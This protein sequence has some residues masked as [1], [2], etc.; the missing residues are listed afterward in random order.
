M[1][2]KILRLTDELSEYRK[3][4]LSNKEEIENYLKTLDYTNSKS[5]RIKNQYLECL[6]IVNIYYF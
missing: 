6:E 3:L 2:K 4:L 1:M 5:V